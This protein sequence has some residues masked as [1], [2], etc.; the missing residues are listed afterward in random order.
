MNDFAPP[1][2]G[3]PTPGPMAPLP[4]VI[5]RGP[6]Q[7]PSESREEYWERLAAE[8]RLDPE[9]AELIDAPMREPGARRVVEL[10]EN[11]EWARFGIRGQVAQL[12]FRRGLKRKAV[13]FANC[14]RLG[15]PGLCSLYPFE[16]KFYQQHGCDVIFCRECADNSRRELF[17]DYLSVVSSVLREHGIPSGWVLAR[18][19]FTLRSDGSPITP[20][21]V[22][23]FNAAVRFTMRKSIGS[24]NGYG[25]L[26]VD[27]VGFEKRGHIAERK[28]G[29]LNL[30]CHG[31]YFG[32][33]VDWEKTR[34]IGARETEARFGV[35]S[36]GFFIQKIAVKNGG[37]EGAVRWALNHMLKYTSKPPAVSAERLA[38]LISA[39]NG[40]RRVH[41][42]GL[43]YGRKPDR[44]KKDRQCPCP[45]C[46]ALGIL[47]VVSF[48]GHLL[49]NGGSVPR[50]VELGQLERDGYEKL[51]AAGRAAVLS[52]GH[53]G[54]GSP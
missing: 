49:P 9:Y 26:F 38:D 4:A 16:H 51:S 20:E 11:P 36:L 41:S 27:E 8:A 29:G 50:L 42:L 43:F 15:R 40:A 3:A 21:R 33:L 30:H 18:I 47:S 44:E 17:L 32:P 25:M 45:K 28:S 12:L 24:R 31:L 7:L 13:R 10:E 2:S 46:R 37:I 6:D 34:D 14:N 54:T 5:P 35:A 1:L 48:E 19:N 52:M 22:K 53:S 23:K 39:F